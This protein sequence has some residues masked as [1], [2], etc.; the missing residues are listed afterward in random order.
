MGLFLH[1][2]PH[3]TPL[4]D[5]PLADTTSYKCRQALTTCRRTQNIYFN[6][7]RFINVWHLY[8]ICPWLAQHLTSV[9]KQW[10]TLATCQCTR[11]IRFNSWRFVNGPVWM[12]LSW[13]LFTAHTIL[14]LSLVT[15]P[16]FIFSATSPLLTCPTCFRLSGTQCRAVARMLDVER[17]V[18]ELEETCWN[19][20]SIGI[21]DQS[22]T[23]F[24]YIPIRY[25]WPVYPWDYN[26]WISRYGFW[27]VR[28]WVAFRTPRV[29]RA[30]P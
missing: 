3:S 13:F 8:L 9:V 17:S 12:F 14:H 24:I 7:G 25:P 5:P 19:S 4:L 16:A 22:P 11:N 29:A 2:P 20:T 1:P 21:I 27:W 23:I 28:V 10:Q 30:I 18:E 26:P 15:S 6:S